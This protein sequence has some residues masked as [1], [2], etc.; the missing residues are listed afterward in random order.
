MRLLHF[1]WAMAL[2]TVLV[3]TANAGLTVTLGVR[4]S[5]GTGPIGANNAAAGS[6]QWIE[7]DT[8]T[9]AFDGQWHTLTWNLDGTNVSPSTLNAGDTVLNGAWGTLEHLRFLNSDGYSAPMTIYIDDIVVTTSAGTTVLT[10]FE[11]YAANQQ[12][13]FRQPSFSSST[14]GNLDLA[15]GN[16]TGISNASAQSGTSS[17]ATSFQFKDAATTNWL[18]LTTSGTG[19]LGNPALPFGAGNSLSVSFRAVPEPS[20]LSLLGLAAIGILRRRRK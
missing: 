5:G 9:F 7:K 13:V 1:A 10:D 8:Q 17:L 3:T 11:G 19:T 20:S 18:R 16:S 12:V 14:T 4:E 6:I 2:A 15:G